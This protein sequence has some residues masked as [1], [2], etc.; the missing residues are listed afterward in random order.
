MNGKLLIIDD[1]EW[2]FE[3]IFERL[4]HANIKF[5]YFKTGVDGFNNFIKA[6][7][8]EYAAIILDM[9]IPFGGEL[10]DYAYKYDVPG[11]FFLEKIRENNKSIP[12]ICYTVLSNEETKKEILKF[13]AK[14]I[15]KAQDS[16]NEMIFD[17]RKYLK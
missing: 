13:D 7:E 3:P 5:D 1:E 16:I 14:Y 9:K 4:N 11:L 10:H 12:I 17:I 8:N 2:Y 6:K 15:V